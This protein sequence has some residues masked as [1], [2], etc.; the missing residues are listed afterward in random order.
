MEKY[1]GKTIEELW[2]IIGSGEPQVHPP[3]PRQ[4]SKPSEEYPDVVQESTLSPRDKFDA[5][6][7]W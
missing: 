3:L 5:A 7:G 2:A 1:N 6:R 4:E